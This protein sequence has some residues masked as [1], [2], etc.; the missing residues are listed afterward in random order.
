MSDLFRKLMVKNAYKYM[1][2]K[3]FNEYLGL[4]IKCAL[5]LS[6]FKNLHN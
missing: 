3:K 1:P 2:K 4:D 5:N 6:I